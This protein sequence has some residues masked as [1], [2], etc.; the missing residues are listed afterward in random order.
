ML[1]STLE[2]FRIKLPAR[3][4]HRLYNLGSEKWK[5]VI[6]GFLENQEGKLNLRFWLI[7]DN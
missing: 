4:N 3:L 7:Y 1:A 5:G 6:G 2:D